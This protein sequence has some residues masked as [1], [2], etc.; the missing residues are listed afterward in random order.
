[1]R[2]FS[3]S[4]AVPAETGLRR[5]HRA[6]LTED[7]HGTINQAPEAFECCRHDLLFFTARHRRHV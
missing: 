5:E 6:R 3:G 7:E 2:S 4:C 1:M